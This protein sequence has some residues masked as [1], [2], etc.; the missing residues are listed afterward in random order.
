MML[1]SWFRRVFH[2]D[3]TP[4]PTVEC[5]REEVDNDP[6]EKSPGKRKPLTPGEI[7]KLSF[8]KDVTDFPIEA[9]AMDSCCDNGGNLMA[10]KA[11]FSGIYQGISEVQAMWYST[12]GFIGFQMCAIIS[13]QWLVDKACTVPAEDAFRNGY[14]LSFNDGSNIDKKVLDDIRRMDKR[15]KIRKNLEQFVRMGKVFGIRHAIFVV[16][17]NDP[18]YYEK[19]FN[20]A[21]VR[22]GSYKGISQVDPYWV[23]PMLDA[24]A[25]ANPASQHFYEPTYWQINGKKYHR[26]HLVIMIN[27]EVP[28]LLKPSYYYG[29]KPLT[30]LIY[31]RVYASERCANE[32]PQLL[33]TKRSTV[34]H[35]DMAAAMA[36][37]AKFEEKM[38]YWAYMRD[39]YGVKAIGTKEEIEQFDTALADLDETIMTQYQLVAAVANVPA[40][41]LLGTSPKGF[42]ATGEYDE[43]SYHESLESIQ[44][45]FGS[46]LLERHHALLMRSA[47]A[48]KYFGGVPK[49]LEA[50]WNPT[51][52]PTAEELATLNK[53][54]AET[55]KALIDSG[56]IDGM[57]ERKRIAADPESG[58]SGLEI[59]DV[60]E[61][62][63]NGGPDE[64]ETTMGEPVQADNAQ[65]VDPKP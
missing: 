50:V 39:N 44:E 51:D 23:T 24:D 19:P 57:D 12:Q 36:N 5:H 63:P 54:K 49:E 46:P 26:S 28:D 20:L 29:G 33:S 10:M 31:E 3:P 11:G 38:E 52:A 22:P 42:N 13:Q 41:K 21:G 17:S 56:A 55:G 2:G 15:F 64:E 4:P 32:A 43:S 16:E 65:G 53:T 18:E 37:P 48:P 35:T 34:I 27:S 30:Q 45:H 7:L 62:I 59:I 61:E 8:Q 1:I 6:L 47:I 58:Y 25:A 40:T 60:F 9:T 14:T